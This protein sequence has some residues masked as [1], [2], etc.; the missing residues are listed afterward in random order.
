MGIKK[1]IHQ[2]QNQVMMS[3]AVYFLQEFGSSP[4]ILSQLLVT[5]HG[6]LYRSKYLQV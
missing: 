5:I 2:K 6:L 1:N 4:A 3:W